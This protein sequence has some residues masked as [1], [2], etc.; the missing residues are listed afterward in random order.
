MYT[1]TIIVVETRHGYSVQV[2]NNTGHVVGRNTDGV[3]S[4]AERTAYAQAQDNGVN[5]NNCEKQFF[6]TVAESM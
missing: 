6:S 5:Y 4:I 2:T 1:N 3:L